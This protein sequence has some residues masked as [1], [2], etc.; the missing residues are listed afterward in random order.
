MILHEGN[1]N[2][3]KNLR[4]VSALEDVSESGIYRQEGPTSGYSFTTTLNLNSSDGRQQL[5]IERGGG[6]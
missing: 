5:T 2:P 6:E 1:Y 4:H 3:F